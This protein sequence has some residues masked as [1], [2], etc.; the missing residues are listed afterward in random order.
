MQLDLGRQPRARRFGLALGLVLSLLTG[1]GGGNDA[2]A[3][4][5]PYLVRVDVSGS[6]RVT[7]PSG[8]DCGSICSISVPANTS[9][10][11]TA[12]PATG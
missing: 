12:V 6:G 5:A 4:D 11:L 9:I 10:T 3:G 2:P 8:I 7:S 1:C